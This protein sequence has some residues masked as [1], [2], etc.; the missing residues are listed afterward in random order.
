MKWEELHK[1]DLS[2]PVARISKEAAELF[3][4]DSLVALLI[5]RGVNM[6]RKTKIDEHG[7]VFY[8]E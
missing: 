2:K 7:Q 3:D 5:S 6:K 1:P 8:L 4:D